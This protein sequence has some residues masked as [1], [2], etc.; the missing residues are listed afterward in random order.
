MQKYFGQY[1][2]CDAMARGYVS[3]HNGL[4]SVVP[5]LC[6]DIHIAHVA[7]VHASQRLKDILV[8]YFM[9]ECICVRWYTHHACVVNNHGGNAQLI[10]SLVRTMNN[11]FDVWWWW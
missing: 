2:E 3:H 7:A 9:L 8:R 5:L 10:H 6:F 4:P 11:V 1:V